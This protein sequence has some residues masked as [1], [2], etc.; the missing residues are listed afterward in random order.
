MWDIQY[1][2]FILDKWCSLRQKR[3]KGGLCLA[4]ATLFEIQICRFCYWEKSELFLYQ[5]L[6]LNRDFSTPQLERKHN[7]NKTQKNWTKTSLAP[8]TALFH[9]VSRETTSSRSLSGYVS[10]SQV[11][12]LP[13]CDTIKGWLGGDQTVETQRVCAAG[14][15]YMQITEFIAFPGMSCKAE[16]PGMLRAWA[17][18]AVAVLLAWLGCHW[19]LSTCQDSGGAR[20]DMLGGMGGGRGA[21]QASV[22]KAWRG[23]H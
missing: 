5:E 21:F 4:S 23:Q 2:D 10:L 22:D 9:I 8:E 16:R 14:T 17:P 3:E 18:R 6:Q 19:N 15:S 7:N 1:K 20:E 11:T 13:R 12:H